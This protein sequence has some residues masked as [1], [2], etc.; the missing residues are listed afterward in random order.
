M[1]NNR[2]ED[3]CKDKNCKRVSGKKLENPNIEGH[4]NIITIYIS[5]I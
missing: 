2:R 3:Q 5:I 1:H 4:S